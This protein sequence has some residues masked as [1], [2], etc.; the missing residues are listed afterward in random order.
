MHYPQIARQII[1]EKSRMNNYNST[2]QKPGSTLTGENQGA[3]WANL[4]V[5]EIKNRWKNGEQPDTAA[6]LKEHPELIRYRSFALD[7]AN[8]EYRYRLEKGEIN[9]PEEFAS[10]FPALQNSLN[11]FIL[12]YSILDKDPGFQALQEGIAW[13]ESSDQFLGY[14]IVDELGR[15]TFGRVYLAREPALGNRRIALKIATG[16]G[17]EAEILGQLQHPNIIPVYSV[18]QDVTT[19]LTAVCMPFLGRATFQD[20]L[21]RA[22]IDKKPPGSARTILDIIQNIEQCEEDVEQPPVDAMLRQ[23]SYV[24]GVIYIGS[25][26]ADALAYSH[27]RGVCHRDLKPSNVLLS[28]DGHPLLLDFNLSFDVR[29]P[30]IKV[31]GTLPYMAPEEL[32][33]IMDADDDSPKWHYDPRSDIYSLGVILYELLTGSFPFKPIIWDRSLK[34]VACELRQRQEEGIQP[35]Q[36]GNHRV[37]RR[38]S[39]LIEACLD[40]NPDQ[41]PNGASELAAT[42][43]K[44]LR[45]LR[46][47]M[48]WMR[49]HPRRVS[50]ACCLLLLVV[51]S[52]AGFLAFRPPLHVRQ[53]HQAQSHFEQAEYDL[54]VNS[55][56]EP[57]RFDPQNTDAL[58]IRARAL[59]KLGDYNMAFKDFSTI[60]KIQQPS[61]ELFACMGYCLN[62][63]NQHKAA[64]DAYHRAI[65][66]GFQNARI[67][68]NI[69]YTYRCI[70]QGDQAQ[71]YLVRAVELDD[72]FPQAHYNLVVLFL[73]KARNGDTVRQASLIYARKAMELGSPSADIYYNSATLYA[74]GSLQN[75][76]L[77]PTTLDYLKKAIENGIDPNVPRVDPVFSTFKDNL[78]FMKVLSSPPL[79]RSSIKAE[80][81]VDPL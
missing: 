59:V 69:G 3:V 8:E 74:L 10:R 70:N 11:M 6:I 37:D 12:V 33:K 77:I 31:G 48:R 30:E 1:V 15:G 73:N 16:G 81:V 61:P 63:L 2:K 51:G 18:Q 42:L 7:L 28:W 46:R 49:N 24:D 23:C 75:A 66:G 22:F 20:V 79:S 72:S 56:N 26:L 29:S 45:P 21:D 36:K 57:L 71:E 54:A 25:Q 55:L 65:S 43:R 5:S 80:L 76:A 40:F 34:E 4:L 39:R 62:K 35:L 53:L 67:F 27:Q 52:F 50:I 78:D 17:M 19:G 13:P 38:L 32:K 44:E 64:L 41:R 14:K 60:C 47:W 68:N 9:D 58:F